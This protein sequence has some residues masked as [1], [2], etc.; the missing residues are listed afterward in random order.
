MGGPQRRAT[1]KK[2]CLQFAASRANLLLF[3]TWKGQVVTIC[4]LEEANC[5]K[6]WFGRVKLLQ[7]VSRGKTQLCKSADL[8]LPRSPAGMAYTKGPYLQY[9]YI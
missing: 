9:I 1:T 8:S 7:F 3:A 5:S 4:G 6:L 2:K